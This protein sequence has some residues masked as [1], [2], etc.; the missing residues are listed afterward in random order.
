MRSLRFALALPVLASGA[1]ITPTNPCDPAADI[2]LQSAGTRIRGVV[3]DQNGE[4]RPGV[5]VSIEGRADT[6]VSG[7]D[8]SFELL[9]LPPA[10]AYELAATPAPPLVGGR[11]TTGALVCRGA[12]DDVELAIVEPPTS[13]EIELAR[14][15][16]ESRLFAAFGAVTPD[17][18]LGVD[19]ARFFDSP[20]G[21]TYRDSFD[22][23]DDCSAKASASSIAYR[24]QVRAPFEAW[25]DAVLAPSPWIAPLPESDPVLALELDRIDD[26]CAAAACAQ[27]S[28]LEPSLVNANARCVDVIGTRSADVDGARAPFVPLEPFGSYQVR[29]LA[30][31]RTPDDLRE[32]FR[33]PQ[34]V[35][36]DA[37]TAAAQMTLLP[38]SFLPVVDASGAPREVGEI[39]GVVTTAGGRFALVENDTLSVIGDGR[40][41]LDDA[42]Q[43]EVGLAPTDDFG[44]EA[45]AP[46]GAYGDDA[47]ASTNAFADFTDDTSAPVRPL[48]LLPAGDWVRVIRREA[49]TDAVDPD[50]VSSTIQ[51]IYVGADAAAA[52]RGPEQAD[53]DANLVEP[54]LR[55]DPADVDAEQLRAFKYL[56]PEGSLVDIGAERDDAYVLLYGS[57]FVLTEQ[58][59]A[60]ELALAHFGS[61]AVTRESDGTISS[62]GWA[63][64]LDGEPN[65]ALNGAA[66]SALKQEARNPS[67]I[68]DSGADVNVSVC[69]DVAAAL[70]EEVD[71]RDLAIL[72]DGRLPP[73]QIFSDARND[74]VLVAL[75]DDLLCTT[76]TNVG[77][78]APLAERLQSVEVGREPVGMITTRV[79]SC[80]PAGADQTRDVVLVANHGSGDLSVV[81][82]EF[83]EMRETGVVPLPAFPVAFL[84]DPEGP[85][86]DDPFVWVIADDGR[87]IPVDMRGEPSAPT[88]NGGPCEVGTRGRGFVGAVAR[89]IGDGRTSS[90]SRALIGGDRLLGELGFFR[91]RALTGAAFA[92][93]DEVAESP[94]DQDR[95]SD[96]DGGEAP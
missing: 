87:A 13:P 55:I 17:V 65:A 43:A 71:L 89:N 38:T 8:G 23:V 41:T 9:N 64:S 75:R 32:R 59:P 40:D 46:Q 90:K 74:R 77:N 91:P 58:A 19:L 67:G 70:G 28:Y 56:R 79:L 37:P 61:N 92:N 81:E 80:G 62:T 30:E 31:L 52:E 51:K 10:S 53:A 18:E 15:S 7:E 11:A 66:C 78:T 95:G 2:A 86:C 49:E 69:F 48:A 14:A 84:D 68:D 47:E 60:S 24:V 54:Q 34:R 50:D 33:L 1:C 25:V 72:D 45:G 16:G 6:A 73:S 93:V 88:C 85:T 44:A 20:D 4:P 94:P 27:F 29:I 57:A 12:I 22:V 21:T 36:A 26:V 35:S 42:A 5:L 76:C 63:T 96:G 82:P 83:G 39:T 3:V